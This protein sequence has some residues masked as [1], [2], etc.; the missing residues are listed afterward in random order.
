ME[1]DASKILHVLA[2]A[3][4]GCAV[5]AGM[6]IG[7]YLVVRPPLDTRVKG[8]LVLGLGVFPIGVAIGGN[9]VGFERSKENRFCGSCHVMKPFVRST[10]PNIEAIASYH[11][12]NRAF[13]R[14]SCYT[15]HSDY[16]L[17]GT[18]TT[19]IGGLR[20]LWIYYTRDW[21]A[22]RGG[23]PPRPIHLYRPM[24]TATCMQCHSTTLPHFIAEPEHAALLD[25]LRAGT[26]FCAVEG[27]HGPA[28][29]G[30]PSRE[31]R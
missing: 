21:P 16:G 28:H 29:L 22:R 1:H 25:D 27:C 9:L 11:S 4:L 7:W 31:R 12:R 3:T 2:G 6:I 20:H 18:L 23:A 8:L 14:E 13:G 10:G 26:V 17:F 30:V 15:C 19:K 24:Q 5:F